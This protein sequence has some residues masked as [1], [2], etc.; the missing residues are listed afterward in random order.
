M[1][2]A[3]RKAGFG[4]EI[5]VLSSVDWRAAL[6]SAAAMIAMLRLKIGMLPTLAGSA[7]AGLVLLGLPA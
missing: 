1:F 7:L 2:S 6:L 4:M 3:V 5:P